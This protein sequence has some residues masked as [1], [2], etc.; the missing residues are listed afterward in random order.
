MS[1]VRQLT[2]DDA[3]AQAAKAEGVR[4]VWDRTREEWRGAAR[5]YVRALLL[6]RPD[7]AEVTPDEI[8]ACV[9][10]EPHHPNVWGAFTTHLLALGWIS[11]A[12]RLKRSAQVKGHG[13]RNEIY[14]TNRHAIERSL[15]RAA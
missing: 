8:R 12:G 13:N 14:L 11:Y 7:G 5:A 15:E 6:T 9:P 3:A 10:F 4:L 1:E 2:L